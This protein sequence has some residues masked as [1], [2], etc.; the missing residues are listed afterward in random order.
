MVNLGSIS[1]ADLRLG[2]TQVKAAYLGGQQIWGLGPVVPEY[3][4]QSIGR[5]VSQQ[6]ASIE[7]SEQAGETI[8]L[9]IRTNATDLTGKQVCAAVYL[10]SSD[11]TPYSTFAFGNVSLAGRYIE[12]TT[13]DVSA[14]LPSG[15]PDTYSTLYMKT[16]IQDAGGIDPADALGE[17]LDWTAEEAAPVTEVKSLKFTALQPN[18]TVVLSATGAPGGQYVYSTNGYDFQSYTLGDSIALANEGD[19]VWFKA[20]QSNRGITYQ[21]YV[22]FNGSG[23]VAAEGWP[24]A[25]TEPEEANWISATYA[26]SY[27]GLFYKCQN[28]GS[29]VARGEFQNASPVHPFGQFARECPVLSSIV[30][31]DVLSAS[32]Q[33]AF[34]YSGDGMFT[35]AFCKD[36]QLLRVEF[37]KLEFAKSIAFWAACEYDPALLSVEFPSMT[38][39]WNDA[40]FG[41]FNGMTG[42]PKVVVLSAFESVPGLLAN[43]GEGWKT[44]DSETSVVI[45]DALYDQWTTTQYWSSMNVTYVKASEFVPTEVPRTTFYYSDGT[46]D[47][48]TGLTAINSSS[49]GSGKTLVGVY[50]N[51]AVSC[52]TEAFKNTQLSSAQLLEVRQTG[53]AVFG[54]CSRLVSVD[55]PKLSSPGG[56]MFNDCTSLTGVYLPN[57]LSITNA[58][59]GEGGMWNGC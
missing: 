51:E 22:G 48:Y 46:Q 26:N 28:L 55:L 8:T 7:I 17:V 2:A 36:P 11:V 40:F 50:S 3:D 49:Y 43:S 24:E 42:A 59:S 29:L 5:S 10:G 12:G 44:L 33:T 35:N 13:P 56:H 18:S 53:Y 20:A 16:W 34:S 6:G 19:S 37:P 54:Q 45:P 27:Y 21:N 39:A 25:M 15:F 38:S 47:D 57:F 31:P 4:V 32:G 14:W 58:G 30:F 1:I 23:L 9:Y 52:A 41:M